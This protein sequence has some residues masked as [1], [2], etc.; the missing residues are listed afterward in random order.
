MPI[1]FIRKYPNGRRGLQEIARDPAIESLAAEFIDHAGRYLCEIM[2][3]G[4]SHLMAII[5]KADGCVKVAD[6]LVDNG[7]ELLEAVDRLITES[8]KHIPIRLF[9][10]ANKNFEL[11][12]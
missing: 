2:P 1:P 10:P 5:D 9:V 7:P 8:V 4:K 3:E 6:E 12:K 11:V